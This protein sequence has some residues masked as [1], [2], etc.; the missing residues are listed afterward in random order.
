MGLGTLGADAADALKRLGFSVA[1]WSRS[2]KAIAGVDCFHGEQQLDHFCGDRHPRR[3]L[4]LTADTRHILDR[5]LFEKLVRGSPLGAPV[6]INAGRGGV[7]E[8]SRHFAAAWM[9][10]RSAAPRSTST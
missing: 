10:A 4:P 1:G 5:E 8:R 2:P 3:L 9:T 7:A 6:L